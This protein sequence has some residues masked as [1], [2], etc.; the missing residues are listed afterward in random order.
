M[1]K[2]CKRVVD[3]EPLIITFTWTVIVFIYVWEPVGN[4]L[5]FLSRHAE[6]RGELPVGEER[7][8]GCCP[9]ALAHHLQLIGI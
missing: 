3:G 9:K 8:V 4:R 6:E 5:Y 2:V 1:H 7:S